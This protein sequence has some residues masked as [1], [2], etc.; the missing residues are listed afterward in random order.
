VDEKVIAGAVFFHTGNKALYKYGASDMKYQILRPN[1]LIMW[2]AIKYFGS[3]GFKSLC[4]GRTDRDQEGLRRFKKGWGCEESEIY[5]YKY[6]FHTNSF[7]TPTEG[8]SSIT[9]S[10]FN[11]MPIFAS[12][13]IGKILYRHVG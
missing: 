2:E 12:R 13:I 7:N 6:N 1:N 3:K 11:K 9:K 4:F 8:V 5:Y 10:V